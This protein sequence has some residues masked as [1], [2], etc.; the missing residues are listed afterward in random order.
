MSRIEGKVWGETTPILQTPM[1]EIHKVFIH[2]GGQCSTHKHDH[3][4]NGFLVV[5]GTVEIHVEKNDYD[6]VDKTVL[7]DGEFTTVKPGEFHYFKANEDSVLYEIYYIDPIQED[8]FRKN[9]GVANV[10]DG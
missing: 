8:I 2:S 3:K 6:L 1:I 5:Q 9:V 7:T 4:W 10:S